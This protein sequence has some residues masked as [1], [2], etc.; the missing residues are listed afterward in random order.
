ML[1]NEIK[2][3]IN[4]LTTKKNIYKTNIKYN[5]FDSYNILSKKSFSENPIIIKIQQ[6]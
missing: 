3:L 2:L 6:Q 5:I 1:L 4:D